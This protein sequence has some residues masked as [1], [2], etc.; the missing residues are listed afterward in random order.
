[1]GVGTKW[2]LVNLET[3][4]FLGST[5]WSLERKMALEFPDLETAAKHALGWRVNSTAAAMLYP[6]S[7]RFI[8]F[9]WLTEAE[10]RISN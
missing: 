4:F 3:G 7:R 8:G 6:D 2:V 5:G 1:M 9:L 10:A